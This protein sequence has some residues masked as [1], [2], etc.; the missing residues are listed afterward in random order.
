MPLAGKKSKQA[1]WILCL[2][3]RELPMKHCSEYEMRQNFS[4]NLACLRKA[5][6]HRLS[7]KGLARLLHL[8]EYSIS[9]YEA[10]RAAPSAY[11]VYQTA[12]YFGISMERL[13]TTKI[14]KG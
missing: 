13:L 14:Q 3:L 2:Q 11:A 6:R 8:S 7:Q 4:E 1:A 10:N 5:D 12:S 9:M